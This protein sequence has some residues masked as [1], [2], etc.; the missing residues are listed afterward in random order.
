MRHLAT[1]L[2]RAVSYFTKSNEANNEMNN[3]LEAVDH[4]TSD[5]ISETT[6]DETAS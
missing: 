1:L 2:N 3:M 6:H 5:E 4:E